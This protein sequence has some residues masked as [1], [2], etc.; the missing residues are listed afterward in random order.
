MPIAIDFNKARGERIL[1]SL[2]DGKTIECPEGGWSVLRMIELAGACF[3]ASW[4]H[5]PQLIR[6]DLNDDDPPE[7]NEALWAELFRELHAAIEFQGELFK[8]LADGEYDKYNE[9]D[10]QALVS[11]TPEG[12][13]VVF[14][15][16]LKK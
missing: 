5:G 10:L 14:R 1:A 6:R 13:R 9:P 15:H 3:F 11:D 4:S 7:R 12:N 8:L 16:G 2:R